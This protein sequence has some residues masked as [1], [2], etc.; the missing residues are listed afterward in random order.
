MKLRAVIVLYAV[1]SAGHAQ[2]CAPARLAAKALDQGNDS[3]A[4]RI[5]AP[6]ERAV[7]ACNEILLALARLRV[8][9]KQLRAA[10]TLFARYIELAPQDA[11]GH[12]QFALFLFSEGDYPRAD[13]ISAKAVALD[14]SNGDALALQGQLLIMKGEAVKGQLL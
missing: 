14:G 3:E 1:A 8:A 12:L 9:Q 4:E 2:T 7:P 10:E 5:L 11:K 6:Y 13:E